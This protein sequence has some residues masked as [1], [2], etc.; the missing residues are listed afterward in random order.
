MLRDIADKRSH[1][2]AIL[3]RAGQQLGGKATHHDDAT[4]VTQAVA[5]VDEVLNAPES[6]LMPAEKQGLLARVIETI[7]PEARRA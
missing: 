6:D 5:T 4:I 7:Y 3:A 2:T 1:I